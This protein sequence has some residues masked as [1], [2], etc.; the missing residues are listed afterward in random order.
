VEA[1]LMGL[2][3]AEADPAEIGRLAADDMDPIGDVHASAEYRLRAG[4][5]LVGRVLAAA[6]S[7]VQKEA[8]LG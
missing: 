7:Q 2:S 8:G 6:L 4:S 3:A 1:A 5:T